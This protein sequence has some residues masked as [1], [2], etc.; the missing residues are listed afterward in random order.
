ME[1]IIWKGIFV[2]VPDGYNSL[3]DTGQQAGNFVDVFSFVVVFDAVAEDSVQECSLFGIIGENKVVK[4]ELKEQGSNL[5]ERL[6]GCKLTLDYLIE[7]RLNVVA[8]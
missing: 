1:V 7:A 5:L 6:K 3:S 2:V 4:E 8:E